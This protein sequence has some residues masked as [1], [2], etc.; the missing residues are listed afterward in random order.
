[1]AGLLSTCSF[2]SPKQFWIRMS[3]RDVAWSGHTHHMKD[4]A[5]LV[6]D[7]VESQ[8]V[9]HFTYKDAA[10]VVEPF[11]LWLA[12]D[13]RLV[14]LGWQVRGP[15]GSGEAGGWRHYRLAEMDS[16]QETEQ[17]FGTGRP[18]YVGPGKEGDQIVCAIEYD[19][20]RH[21]EGTDG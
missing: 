6:C 18:G 3:L 7:A 9:L 13:G 2:N 14:L 4:P 12:D 16:L 20:P 15:S 17:H 5:R 8:T 19:A 11:A 10:R 21:N 1:M